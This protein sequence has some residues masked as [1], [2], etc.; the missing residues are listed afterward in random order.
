L[1]QVDI[2]TKLEE[3][4]RQ[5]EALVAR[6]SQLQ[7]EINLRQQEINQLAP[8]VLR[9]DGEIRVLRSLDSGEVAKTQDS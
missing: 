2:K 1:K 8:E 9:L 6:I 7:Q 4:T 5:R 3:A